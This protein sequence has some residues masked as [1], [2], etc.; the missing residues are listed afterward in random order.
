M[1]LQR[2]LPRQ[3]V[4]LKLPLPKPLQFCTNL[5]APGHVQVPEF[6]HHLVQDGFN[7]NIF[8][9]SKY[10]LFGYLNPL[11]KWIPLEPFEPW[12]LA[13]ALGLASGDADDAS[14]EG[15]EAAANVLDSG[16]H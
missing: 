12:H 10:I 1:F 11:G 8:L 15:S 13:D 5:D 16:A 2:L 14:A 4:R 6:L 3:I 9:R 7:M